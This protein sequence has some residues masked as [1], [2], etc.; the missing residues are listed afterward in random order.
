MSGRMISC[1][2]AALV[3]SVS[4]AAAAQERPP[5]AAELLYPVKFLCGGASE[6]FQEGVVRGQHATSISLHNPSDSRAVNFTKQVSRALPFQRSGLGSAVVVDTLQPRA[7]IDIECNEIRMMLL[8]SMTEQFRSG[9]LRIMADGALNV[10]AVYS[11][12]PHNADV[13]TVDVETVAGVRLRGGS[14]GILP[15]LIV[16]EIDID[17][18]GSDCPPGGSICRIRVNVTV[19]NIGASDSGGFD[20]RVTLDPGQSV[21]ALKSV[22]AGLGAGDKLTFTSN[23]TTGRNCVAPDC[24]ICALAD[25]GNA[26]TESDESNNKLCA[27]VKG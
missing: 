19:E 9:F 14:T 17:T 4:A 15:D 7:S 23:A 6:S 5:I 16:S 27:K 26:V 1:F 21:L 13:S 11:S 3:V 2:T 18:P 22:P 12:R 10:V 8:Q 24:R 25:V 20:V